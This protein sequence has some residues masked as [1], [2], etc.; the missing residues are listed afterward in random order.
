MGRGVKGSESAAGKASGGGPTAE[1]RDEEMVGVT[2]TV[3]AGA[4][5]RGRGGSQRGRDGGVSGEWTATGRD[6]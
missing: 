3:G 2:E 5:W 1:V 6:R 4:V